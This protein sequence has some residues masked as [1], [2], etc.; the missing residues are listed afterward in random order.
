MKRNLLNS[1]LTL[2]FVVLTGCNHSTNFQSFPDNPQFQSF[3][4]SGINLKS[5]WFDNLRPELQAYYAEAKGKT[6]AELFDALHNII[7][8]NNKIKSYTDSKSFMYE[9]LDN[10]SFNN[11]AGVFDAY[12]DAFVPGTGGDGNQYLEK[13]DAAGDFIN[14]E[15][16]WPQSFFGKSLPMVGDLHH[17]Q[18]TLSVPNRMRSDFP[19]GVATG[20]ITYTTSGGSKLGVSSLNGESIDSKKLRM[21]LLNNPAKMHKSD[22]VSRNVS[23]VFEPWDQQKGGTARALLY[24][25]LRYFDANIRQGSFDK[26]RFWVSNVA[27][28]IKWSE[29]VDPVNEIDIKRNELVFK[30]QGN[31]NPFVDIPNLASLIGEAVLKSK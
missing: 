15:H 1:L 16:T 31:R 2:S 7:S 8:R 4:S 12:S 9:T 14:C 5:D 24:F 29:V 19:I 28:F 17:L 23:A 3:N 26:N 6:G 22:V 11:R 20:S 13:G 18:A 25:Y 30:K 27:D 21:S 10:I